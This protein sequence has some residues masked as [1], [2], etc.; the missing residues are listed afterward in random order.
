MAWMQKV[1]ILKLKLLFNNKNKEKACKKL[2]VFFHWTKGGQPMGNGI[3][4]GKT[5]ETIRIIAGGYLLYLDYTLIKGYPDFKPSQRIFFI[6]C[7]IAFAV[8]GVTV[9]YFALKDMMKPE[10]EEKTEA[11]KSQDVLEQNETTGKE[12]VE[13]EEDQKEQEEVIVEAQEEQK[14]QEEQ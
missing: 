9:I 2:H 5:R 10:E 11:D 12:K 6:I 4:N 1:S 14:D 13:V 3:F 7:M 8:T